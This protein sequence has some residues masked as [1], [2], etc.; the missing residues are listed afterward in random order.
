MEAI[1]AAR[2]ALHYMVKLKPV[3]SKYVNEAYKYHSE[4]SRSLAAESV[5]SS[6]DILTEKIQL[7]RRLIR[8]HVPIL[9]TIDD[10]VQEG[11]GEL[12]ELYSRTFR[13][14]VI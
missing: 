4:H 8:V 7:I 10:I 5:A 3:L 13:T 14:A 6:R 11:K 9:N 1:E 12:R 2:R